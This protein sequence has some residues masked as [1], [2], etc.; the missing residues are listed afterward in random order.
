MPPLPRAECPVCH[1]DIAL[2]SGGELR[3]HQDHRHE[4]YG[5]GRGVHVPNCPASGKTLA[6]LGPNTT[7]E[8]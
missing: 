3:E 1:G 2:R 4:L 5:V 6:Q 7:K 8:G